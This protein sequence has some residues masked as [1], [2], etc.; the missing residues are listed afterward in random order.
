MAIP[1]GGVR[2]GIPKPLFV[3]ANVLKRSM[4]SGIYTTAN[5]H[6]ISY[7][8]LGRKKRMRSEKAKAA[9]AK[10]SGTRMNSDTS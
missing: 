6:Q 9:D 10:K 5:F 4:H 1:S 8:R 7:T 2:L 3:L